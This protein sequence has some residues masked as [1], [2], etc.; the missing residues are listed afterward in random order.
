[1]RV[2]TWPGQVDIRGD[3]SGRPKN[4][5]GVYRKMCAKG[6]GL[7]QVYD[8]RAL[9]V[10]VDS[11]SDCYEV[12]REVSTN[13]THSCPVV[14]WLPIGE[15]DSPCLIAAVWLYSRS[16]VYLHSSVLAFL[17]VSRC[18]LNYQV[19]RLWKP[20]EG[21]FKDYIRHK[22]DNGYQSLHTVV[23]GSDGVPMEVQIRTQKMHW[24]AEYGVA[25]HWRYKEA[26]ARFDSAQEHHVSLSLCEL[27]FSIY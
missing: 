18:F 5:W 9:R 8:V 10:V 25:A 19:H 20:V 16:T 24:I 15:C 22:K 27:M 6:Y 4:L 2:F 21:R 12:L 26:A 13:I 17:V 11:K 7:D 3:L 1:M 14:I 23:L